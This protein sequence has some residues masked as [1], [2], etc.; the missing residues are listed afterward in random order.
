[1][2][3]ANYHE[4]RMGHVRE[5]THY[6]EQR[7]KQE[8]KQCIAIQHDQTML[9]ILLAKMEIVESYGLPRVTQMAREMGPRAGWS[10]DH[11]TSDADG[12]SWEFNSLE[13]GNRAIRK[14]LTDKPILPI[15][16]PMCIS[17]STMNN[18]NYCRMSAEEVAAGMQYARKRLEFSVKLYKVQAEAG[19]FLLHEHHHG[20]FSLQ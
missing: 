5:A 17:H 18:I 16:S 9:Q 19:R 7:L 3:S 14:V 15:G 4:E 10:L 12:R 6:V 11:I 8:C 13:M 2:I 1:M 20:A